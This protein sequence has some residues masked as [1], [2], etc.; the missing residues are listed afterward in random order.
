MRRQV[1]QRSDG[2]QDSIESGE[3]GAKRADMTIWQKKSP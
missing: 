1:L 2:G 3:G